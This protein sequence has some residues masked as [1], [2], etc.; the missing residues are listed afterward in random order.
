M[1]I[2]IPIPE[3]VE[4]VEEDG[5]ND[6]GETDDGS[7]MKQYGGTVYTLNKESEITRKGMRRWKKEGGKVRAYY[8][9]VSYTHL[10]CL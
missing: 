10:P 1:D 5:W 3:K 7:G 2:Y 6:M 4:M 9:P 8:C